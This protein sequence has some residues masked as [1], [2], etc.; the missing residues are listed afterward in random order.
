MDV[1]AIVLFFVLMFLTW[2]SF[3]IFLIEEIV[4][5]WAREK[6]NIAVASHLG[7]TGL[8]EVREDKE[9]E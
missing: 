6:H 2:V 5:Y 3:S 7:G 4:S 9:P 8:N 1:T